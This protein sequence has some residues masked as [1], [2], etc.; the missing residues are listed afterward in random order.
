LFFR[1]RWYE[2]DT[3]HHSFDQLSK[4]IQLIID[5]GC[6]ERWSKSIFIDTYINHALTLTR[7]YHLEIQTKIDI[8]KLNEILYLLPDVHSLKLSSLSISKAGC[9]SQEEVEFLSFLSP[10]N[11][12]KKI[13]FQNMNE[14]EQ[15]YMLLLICPRIN[16]LQINCIDYQHAEL[17]AGLILTEMKTEPNYSL[18]LLCF[19]VAAADDDMVQKLEKMIHV[20]NLLVNFVIK[21][22]HNNIYLQWK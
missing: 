2:Y 10:K 14:I 5:D 9:I 16:H 11:Q 7:I 18:R 15:L 21:H 4:A 13:C 12:I 17:L 19:Y 20:E 8:G 1:K 6:P 22:V 3:Q